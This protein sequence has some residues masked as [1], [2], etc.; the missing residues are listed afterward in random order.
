[1]VGGSIAAGALLL[2]GLTGSASAVSGTNDAAGYAAAEADV[3]WEISDPARYLTDG[4]HTTT[5]GLSDAKR[6][7]TIKSNLAEE[8]DTWQLFSA[9]GLLSAEGTFSAADAAAN[10]DTDAVEV[11]VP[12]DNSVAGDD[13]NVRV[14]INDSSGGGP[15]Y[16][17]D[18][19]DV[20]D[21][22]VVRRVLFK[23]AGTDHRVNFSPEPYD[24][25]IQVRGKLIRANWETQTYKGYAN[26]NVHIQVRPVAGAYSDIAE[27]TTGSDG[28]V[29]Y[30]FNVSDTGFP[31]PGDTFVGQAQYFGNAT[32]SGN[33]STGDQVAPA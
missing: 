13:L 1:M 25:A 4:D 10:Q 9:K 29:S 32:S 22:T 19:D 23:H 2:A 8:G 33:D 5:V 26:R 20:G 12:H 15:G 7:V 21:L 30:D 16:E 28:S 24:D 18:T 31:A 3:S 17:V 6:T 11:E 14:R 27:V